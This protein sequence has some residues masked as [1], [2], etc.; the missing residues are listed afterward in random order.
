MSAY[1]KFLRKCVLTSSPGKDLHLI[2]PFTGKKE[3][4]KRGCE[5]VLF[6]FD[7]ES[8]RVNQAESCTVVQKI[9]DS[10]PSRKQALFK[11]QRRN[12]YSCATRF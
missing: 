11:D 8:V 7:F 1:E 10:K 6:K 9:Q 12:C 4:P 3:D 5:E 2:N